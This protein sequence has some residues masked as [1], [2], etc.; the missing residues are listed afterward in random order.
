MKLKNIKPENIIPFIILGVLGYFFWREIIIFLGAILLVLLGLGVVAILLGIFVESFEDFGNKK[1]K[2]GII[3]SSIVI[4]FCLLPVIISGDVATLEATAIFWGNYLLVGS[5][6]LLS[7][8][9][10]LIKFNL[11]KLNK[12]SKS[13]SFFGKL[14]KLIVNNKI[15][16]WLTKNYI[17]SIVV[18][19]IGILYLIILMNE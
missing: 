19:V 3:K 15:F 16:K 12:A 7:S 9:F 1:Y 17:A 6:F 13:N 10:A 8:I 2:S 11:G 5:I 14:S 4:G 18:G